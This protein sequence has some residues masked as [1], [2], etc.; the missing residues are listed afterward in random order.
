MRPVR[1]IQGLTLVAA[2]LVAC[3]TLTSFTLIP[4]KAAT[5][6]DTV[7]DKGADLTVA[8]VHIVVPAGAVPV[9]TKVDASFEGHAPAGIDGTNLTTL[10]KAFKIKL[11][12][13]LEPGPK[14]HA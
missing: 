1:G 7:T 6:S 8:G 11:G 13:G 2:F 9:E 12:N 10:A 3:L 4:Q 14:A 5:A